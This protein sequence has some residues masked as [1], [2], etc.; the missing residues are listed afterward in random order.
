MSPADLRRAA[1]LQAEAS[2][3]KS[4]G[5]LAQALVITGRRG[6]WSVWK[7]DSFTYPVKVRKAISK[8]DAE[9]ICFWLQDL[10]LEQRTKEVFAY[11][12]HEP[13]WNVL[14]PMP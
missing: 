8:E 4:K 5:V 6:I 2:R 13:A 10:A 7:M 14:T 1:I 12:I 11:S 3:S 9:S